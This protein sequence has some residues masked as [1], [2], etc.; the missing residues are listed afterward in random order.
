MDSAET[1]WRLKQSA[2]D[3]VARRQGA[4]EDEWA[5]EW[6]TSGGSRYAGD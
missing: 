1:G 5:D 6:R 4:Y 3:E 2:Q